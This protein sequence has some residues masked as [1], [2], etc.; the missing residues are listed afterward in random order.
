MRTNRL[1]LYADIKQVLDSA[2]SAGGGEYMLSSHGEAVHWRQRVYKFR[3]AFAAVYGDSPY[4][5][6]VFPRLEHD[7]RTVKIEVRQPAGIFRPNNTTSTFDEEAENLRR[8][9]KIGESPL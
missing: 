3:K 5:L 4:D 6:L 8:S 9:L 1:N 7:S 2:L